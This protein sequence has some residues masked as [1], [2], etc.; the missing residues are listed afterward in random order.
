MTEQPAALRVALDYFEAWTAK[1]LDRALSLV[2]DELVCDAP[3]GRCVI[4]PMHQPLHR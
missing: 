3:P 1:D 2:D 4:V